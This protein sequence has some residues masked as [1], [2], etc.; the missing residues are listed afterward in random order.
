MIA[1]S[2]VSSVPRPVRPLSR[3]RPAAQA[4]THAGNPFDAG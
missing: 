2:S 3:T 4:G 1:V